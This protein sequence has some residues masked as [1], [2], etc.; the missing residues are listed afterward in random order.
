MYIQ[1]STQEKLNLGIG[2]YQCNWGI[3]IA[4]LYETDKYA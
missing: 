2:N 4:G 3:H 1:T